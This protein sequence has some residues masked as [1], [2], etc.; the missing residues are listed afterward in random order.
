MQR[1]HLL[2]RK[3]SLLLGLYIY[4][5]FFI[6]SCVVYYCSLFVILNVAM[7][8]IISSFMNSGK[9]IY[10]ICGNHTGDCGDDDSSQ[11]TGTIV[12][13]VVTIIVL[14]ILFGLIFLLKLLLKYLLC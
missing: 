8:Y 6:N 10:I 2:L 1:Q 13:I 7:S 4:I 12:G 14:L 11:R 9:Y 5:F 3:L